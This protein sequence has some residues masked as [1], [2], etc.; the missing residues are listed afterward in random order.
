MGNNGVHM[1]LSFKKP[2]NICFR[3]TQLE[4]PESGP[5][6]S[7][8]TWSVFNIYLKLGSNLAQYDGFGSSLTLS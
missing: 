1:G 5:S 3:A 4:I 6:Q 7:S 2:Y 8:S